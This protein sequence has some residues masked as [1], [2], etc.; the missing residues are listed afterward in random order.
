[1]HEWAPKLSDT[2]QYFRYEQVPGLCMGNCVSYFVYLFE[3][4][5]IVYYGE[6]L[7]RIEGL[8]KKRVN[9]TLFNKIVSTLKDSNFEKLKNRYISEDNACDPYYLTDQGALKFTLKTDHLEKAVYWDLGCV[10][11]VDA[12]IMSILSRDIRKLLPIENWVGKKHYEWDY[13]LNSGEINEVNNNKEKN[14]GVRSQKK[15]SKP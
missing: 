14:S 3:D 11:M 10:V 4:G 15:N 8:R 7:N 5:E 9:R 1:M 2:R 13:N 6:G 12:I